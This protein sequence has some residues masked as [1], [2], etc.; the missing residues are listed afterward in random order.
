MGECTSL[1]KRECKRTNLQDVE[2]SVRQDFAIHTFTLLGLKLSGKHGVSNS[3]V[4]QQAVISIY[5][6]E[7][8]EKCSL[9]VLIK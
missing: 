8:F 6:Y 9:I 3:F 2:T 5:A 1:L 4:L 7:R